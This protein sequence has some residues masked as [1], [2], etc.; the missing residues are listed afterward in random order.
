MKRYYLD[1]KYEEREEVKGLG[2]KWDHD[3][4]HWYFVDATQAEKFRKWLPEDFD[5]EAAR[6]EYEESDEKENV[7]VHPWTSAMDERKRIIKKHLEDGR[8]INELAN[9]LYISSSTVDKYIKEMVKD[10][11]LDA[12]KVVSQEKQ[13]VIME[14]IS[15]VGN[16]NKRLAPIKEMLDDSISYLEISVTAIK[17]GLL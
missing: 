7:H 13:A 6:K 11:E 17:N 9:N 10:G 16:W 14:A 12:D 4:R 5:Y 15:K 1:S 8:N 3:K 2:A